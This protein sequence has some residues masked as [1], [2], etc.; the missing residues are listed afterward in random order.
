MLKQSNCV[1]P[2]SFIFIFEFTTQSKCVWTDFSV[3]P[4]FAC[5][6]Y[7][8]YTLLWPATAQALDF[9]KH[10]KFDGGGGPGKYAFV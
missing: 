2:H 4:H 9:Q 6:C 10:I 3:S 7:L 1:L 5:D 8:H